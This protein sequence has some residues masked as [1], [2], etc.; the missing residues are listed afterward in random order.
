MAATTANSKISPVVTGSGRNKATT[1]I[2]TKVTGPIINEKGESTFNT[3]IVQYNDAQGG[4]EKTIGTRDAANGKITWNTNASGRTKLNESVFKK[5]SNNQMLSIENQITSNAEERQ[6]LNKASGAGNRETTSNIT[7]KVA[8]V[9]GGFGGGRGG[10]GS[11]TASANPRTSY[12]KNL[13][14]PTALR[15]TQ[16]DT[17]RISVLE[18]KPKQ[19]QGL[20]FA[21]RESWQG[22]VKGAVTLPIPGGVSDGN[23]TN[24]GSGS[25]TPKDI[26]A[27][28]A[29]KSFL[30]D[31]GAQG[32]LDSMGESMTTIQGDAAGVT[33]AMAN[34]F[35]EQLTGTTDLLSRTQGMV[36]NLIWNCYLKVLL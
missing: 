19:M 17:L 16:Q 24:W 23:K 18:Y 25:M 34:F 13:C 7:S 14:Y 28:D 32:A 22:R 12:S 21:A 31:E 15:R 3:E 27:S 36:M 9:L 4:G 35:T 26:A 11:D 20:A 33:D 30:S 6:G 5:A 8:N 2:S 10:G 1:F 29:V